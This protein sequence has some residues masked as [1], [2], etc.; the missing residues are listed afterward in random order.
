MGFVLEIIESFVEIRP[1]AH[2]K[3]T[4]SEL[5][6]SNG[7][8][9]EYFTLRYAIPVAFF[10]FIDNVIIP[11]FTYFLVIDLMQDFSIISL[12][13]AIIPIF[14]SLFSLYQTFY[15][16]LF[17]TETYLNFWSRFLG[18]T[19]LGCFLSALFRLRFKTKLP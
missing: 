5:D 6:Y 18:E 7:I 4:K 14:S 8:R 11:Y 19:A 17:P 12:L 1:S 16:F 9:S 13:I 15:Y 2:G 10:Q 3:S